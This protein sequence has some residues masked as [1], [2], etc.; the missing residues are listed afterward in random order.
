LFSRPI[1]P[2]VDGGVHRQIPE[3]GGNLR[4]W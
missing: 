3:Y 2:F 1:F 4:I